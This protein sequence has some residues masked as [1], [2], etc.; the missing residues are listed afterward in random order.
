MGIFGKYFKPDIEKLEKRDIKGLVKALR[1]SHYY[2]AHAKR[3]ECDLF[4]PGVL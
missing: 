1:H 3:V 2:I 4:K